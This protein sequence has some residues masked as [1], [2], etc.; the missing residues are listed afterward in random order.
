MTLFLNEEEMQEFSKHIAELFWNN[1][2]PQ[3]IEDFINN[4]FVPRHLVKEVRQYL[5]YF[6]PDYYVVVLSYA[7]LNLR[8]RYKVG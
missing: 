5:K 7:R 1:A 2:N 3:E 4:G 6:D 8:D